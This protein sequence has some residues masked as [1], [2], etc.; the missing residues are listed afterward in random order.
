M[1]CWRAS[2]FLLALCVL[3]LFAAFAPANAH[4]ADE[5]TSK[6]AVFRVGDKVEI[7]INDLNGSGT[8][9]VTNAVT[10]DK[11][12]KVTFPIIPGKPNTFTVKIAGLTPDDAAKA[13]A[14]EY[15]DNGIIAGETVT[16]SKAK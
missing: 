1:N 16:V 9:P 12:G 15:S 13:V 14:K 7:V 3:F 2:V 4:G 10:V 5:A 11:D 8:A 6:P